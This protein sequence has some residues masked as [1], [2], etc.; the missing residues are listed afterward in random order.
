MQDKIINEKFSGYYCKK[1]NFIPFIQI[2][3]KEKNIKIFSSCKCRK[4]YEN[5]DSFIK[6][7]YYC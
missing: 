4:Q 2:I 7:C 3:P 5:I 1:C 6:I